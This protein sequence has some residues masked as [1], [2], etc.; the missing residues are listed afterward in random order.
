MTKTVTLLRLEGLALLAVT[1]TLYA[2][3]GGSWWLFLLLL[4]APDL[5]M[6][7]YLRGPKVGAATYNLGH[8]TLTPV[9]I[10]LVSYVL[11]ADLG[12]QIAIIWLAHIGLDRLVGY[13]LKEPTSF[14]DT[15]L[16]RIG[17]R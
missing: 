15:H 2:V 12:V 13:G 7:G 4:F 6:L 11:G 14:Q 16:G 5:F 8:F 17:R 3:L 1:V 9:I 10:G